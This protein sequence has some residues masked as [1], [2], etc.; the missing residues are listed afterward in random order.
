MSVLS[1]SCSGAGRCAGGRGEQLGAVPASIA[2]ARISTEFLTE[3]LV[4]LLSSSLISEEV[5]PSAQVIEASF[6]GLRAQYPVLAKSPDR[7]NIGLG[8]RKQETQLPLKIQYNPLLV[9]Y[10]QQCVSEWC[11]WVIDLSFNFCPSFYSHNFI[12]QVL[13]LIEKYDSISMHR[14]CFLCQFP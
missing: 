10:R 1:P 4:C 13:W 9:L 12:S 2:P 8:C 11:A 14:K 3:P 6:M 5:S 7:G